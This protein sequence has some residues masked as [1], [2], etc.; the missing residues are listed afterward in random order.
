VSAIATT[1]R[2]ALVARERVCSK[3]LLEQELAE[4]VVARRAKPR[5][6]VSASSIS[7]V[8]GRIECFAKCRSS[9]SAAL[10]ERVVVEREPAADVRER[11]LLRAHRHPVRE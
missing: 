2:V 11:I 10:G 8:S 6:A 4:E 3:Q 9:I 7:T 1:E 5:S